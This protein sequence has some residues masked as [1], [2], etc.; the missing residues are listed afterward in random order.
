MDTFTWTEEEIDLIHEIRELATTKIAERATYL[1]SIGD[2][3]QDWV[4]PE[5]LSR[6]NMLSPAI[7]REYGGRELSM[8]MHAALVEELAAGC[9]GAAAIVV[10]NNY[11]V[12][13]ILVA[14]SKELKNEFLPYLTTKSPNLACTAINETRSDYNLERPEMSS[15]DITRILTFAEHKDETAIING[16]KDYIINGSVAKFMLT[17]AR[18]SESKQ[19]SGLQFYLVP[20]TT[21]GIDVAEVLRK[22]GLRACHTVKIDFHNVTIPE[23][24]KVGDGAGYLLLMQ[25]F[26]RNRTLIGAIGVGVAKAAYEMALE[27]AR[28]NQIFSGTNSYSHYVSSTL[29][30]L[31]TQIDAARLAVMRAAYYID[32]DEN[33]ARVSIMAKLYA[34]Q[35]AQ[36]VTSTAVDLIGRLGFFVGHP[37]EKYLRDA[38]MLSMIAGSDYLH[39][40]ILASQL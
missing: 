25:T 27:A 10:A 14:G 22:S 30:D 39:R 15:E 8:C 5:L 37:A 26:D 4:I 2:E 40:H 18:S 1:D 36:H 33:Y 13:P 11:A 3:T 7:P 21:P 28:S 20:N 32:I 31:S 17:L 9:A 29:A 19:K 38:Q 34:T 24:Y 16:S 35:V 6:R 12:T 23:E